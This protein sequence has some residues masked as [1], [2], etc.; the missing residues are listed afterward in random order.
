[1]ANDEE[2]KSFNERADILRAALKS[3]LG[4]YYRTPK[5]EKYLKQQQKVLLKLLENAAHTAF[6]KKYDFEQIIFSENFI[7]EFQRL[8]PIHNY[9]GIKEW[10]MR[11]LNGEKDVVTKGSLKYFALSSGTS[12]GSTKYVPVSQK[13]LWQFKR[14][15]LKLS[16]QIALNKEIPATIFSKHHLLIGGSIDL[17][18]NGASYIGDLSGIVQLKIPFWYQS[19]SKPGR[20][21]MAMQ[22][23]S[24]IDNIVRDAASWNISMITGIPSWVQIV[25]ERIVEHYQLKDIHE[26]WPEL[27]VYIHSGIRAEPYINSI[28]KLFGQEVFW[29]ESYLASEGF[30]AFKQSPEMEG[31]KLILSDYNFYEFIPFNESNFDSSGN[32]KAGAETLTIKDVKP[33]IDYALL[34]TTCSGAWRYLIGD[35]V[36]FVDIEKAEIIITGRTKHFLSVTGE[37]LSVDNMNKAVSVVCDELNFNCKEFTVYA[38]P[39]D[40][41]F[42]HVWNI[43]CDVHPDLAKLKG[44]LDEKLKELNDD[45]RIERQFALKDIEIKTFPNELFYRFL[46][47]R[48]KTGGQVKFPRVLKGEI[49]EEWKMFAAAQ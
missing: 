42:I 7:A 20:E 14:Q 10:W 23:D 31:M 12:D 36:R 40:G 28:N 25:L 22:W 13:Q 47:N 38:E 43:G 21:V 48:G 6:G 41:G 16:L 29:Y 37:H 30:F 2:H 18:Y 4:R 33:G 27:K 3:P 9:E 5:P 19:F 46:S 39:K 44:I 49:L 45:Y 11:A 35:T 34:I 1:M 26:L 15:T 8:V 32:V 24:K 17:N